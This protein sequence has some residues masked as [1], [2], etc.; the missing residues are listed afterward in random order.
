V[1]QR[2]YGV[3][4]FI[5]LFFMFYGIVEWEGKKE[6]KQA[7]DKLDLLGGQIETHFSS[8]SKSQSHS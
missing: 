1:L 3:V 8:F 7:V 6:E 2:G 5:G 4:V